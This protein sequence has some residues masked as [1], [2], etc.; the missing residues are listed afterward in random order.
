MT[1]EEPDRPLGPRTTGGQD[2]ALVFATRVSNV[3]FG[4]AIRRNLKN[5]S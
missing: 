1:P 2:A 5:A 4:L 3:I